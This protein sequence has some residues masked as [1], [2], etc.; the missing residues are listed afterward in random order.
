MNSPLRRA[1]TPR[2]TT[3]VLGC[4]MALSLL[5]A[6]QTPAAGGTQFGITTRAVSNGDFI[7]TEP[8]LGLNRGMIIV[9]GRICLGSSAAPASP[10]YILITGYDAAHLGMFQRKVSLPALAPGLRSACRGYAATLTGVR[11]PAEL[12]VRAV[13][14]AAK[15]AS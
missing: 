7:L 1:A 4:G 13:S 14:A 9:R 10:A 5:S 6:C 3:S 8:D 12:E 15:A 2:R 11:M